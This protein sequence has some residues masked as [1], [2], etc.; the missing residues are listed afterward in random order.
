L[1]WWRFLGWLAIG[2]FI[3]SLYGVRHSRLAR[4]SV[5][6]LA[7]GLKALAVVTAIAAAAAWWLLPHPTSL[8]APIAML[9]AFS[10]FALAANRRQAA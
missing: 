8:I 3:Y 1:T 5:A 7:S 4:G 9:F 10:A 6:P 2:L